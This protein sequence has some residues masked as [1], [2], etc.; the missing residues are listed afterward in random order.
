MSDARLDC[1]TRKSVSDPS[2]PSRLVDGLMVNW[3]LMSPMTVLYS[4]TKLLM[5]L[6]IEVMSGPTVTVTGVA[7]SAFTRLSVTSGI[8]P[9]TVLVVL[10]YGIP[11]IVISAL[12]PPTGGSNVRLVVLLPVPVAMASAPALPVAWL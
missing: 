2:G 11:L 7:E 5:E 9:V 6:V 10:A 12:V 3:V 8:A 1:K 4:V